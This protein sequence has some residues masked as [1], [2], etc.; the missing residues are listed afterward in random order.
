MFKILASI[1]LGFFLSM[2]SCN[3]FSSLWQECMIDPTTWITGITFSAM[4]LLPHW[5]I[6]IILVS[7]WII[8]DVYEKIKPKNILKRR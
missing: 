8:M 4:I 6:G 1:T 2:I 7:K 5:I 3:I